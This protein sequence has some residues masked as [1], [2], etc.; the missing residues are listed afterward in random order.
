M[1]ELQAKPGESP[2]PVNP[3][4]R[5]VVMGAGVTAVAGLLGFLVPWRAAGAIDAA[6][7]ATAAAA[8][9]SAGAPSAPAPEP[10]MA[11]SRQLT[12]VT[13]LDTTL[14]ARLHAALLQRD[15]DLDAKVTALARN[16]GTAT[17]DTTLAAAQAAILKGWYLGV[18][19]SGKNATVIAYEHALMYAP[20]ADVCVLPTFARGEPHYWARPPFTAGRSA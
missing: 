20:L 1:S 18:V 16:T 5:A 15:P 13:T 8:A 3:S 19:G 2:M 17:A 12:G 4:R 9:G 10:F 14:G 6:S 11:L 7:A